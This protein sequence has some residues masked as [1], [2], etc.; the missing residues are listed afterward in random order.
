MAGWT[1]ISAS[2]KDADSP[3][4]EDLI[5]DL[6]DNATY[7]HER[8]IRS[9]THTT[10]VRTCM[11]RGRTAFDWSTT[12]VGTVSITFAT[13]ADDG[14]PNFLAAPRVYA[15]LAEDATSS[16]EWSSF[17]AGINPSLWI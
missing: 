11:A 9:G 6:D 2:R 16:Q 13:D 1:D 14:D 7:N 5:G 15:T 4:D 10:G 8:A 3:I 12:R 17:S